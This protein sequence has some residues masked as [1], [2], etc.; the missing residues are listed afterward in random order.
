M[1]AP[2]GKSKSGDADEDDAENDGPEPDGGDGTLFDRPDRLGVCDDDSLGIIGI[3][4]RPV[5]FDWL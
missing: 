3:F 4:G 2:A 1:K 5:G